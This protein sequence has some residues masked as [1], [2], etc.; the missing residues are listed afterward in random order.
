MSD[1]SDSL[2]EIKSVPWDARISPDDWYGNNAAFL[3]PFCNRSFVV[4]SFLGKKR[5]CPR[6]TGEAKCVG[7]CT[8]SADKGGRAFAY[9]ATNTE[10]HDENL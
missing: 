10:K 3:C 9:I 8:T 7:I 1:K 5:I 4:S 6:C 2:P